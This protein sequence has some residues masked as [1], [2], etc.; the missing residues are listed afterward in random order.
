KMIEDNNIRI[1]QI[2]TKGRRQ[3]PYALTILVVCISLGVVF[4]LE[5][6]IDKNPILAL[7]ISEGFYIVGWIAL[8]RP[9][10]ALIFDPME[11]RMENKLLRQMID[12][13]IDVVRI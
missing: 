7:A 4:G 1:K 11:V 3:L 2:Q 13:Q 5:V 12:M 6:F 9:M 10:D 8:W